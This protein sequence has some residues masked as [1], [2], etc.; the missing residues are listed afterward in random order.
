[1]K[2]ILYNYLICSTFRRKLLLLTGILWFGMATSL[3]AQKQFAYSGKVNDK[4]GLTLPGVTVAVKGTTIGTITDM[5]GEFTLRT[6]K[7]NAVLTFSLLGFAT[8]E[9]QA[10][11]GETVNLVLEDKSFG[12][13][14]VMIVGYGT[15]KKSLVTGAISQIKAQDIRSIPAS[16]VEQILTGRIAGVSV[17]SNSG[18][19]GSALKVRIRGTGTN[20]N[21][22]PLYI[23][24][25]MKSGDITYLEPSDVESI[26]VLKDAGS[27]AIYG[28]E[29]GNGVVLITTKSGKGVI[30]GPKGGK[31]TYDFQ[32]GWQSV[33]KLMKVMN[34][35]EYATYVNE[36]G[37]KV[38]G[39]PIPTE[40]TVDTKWLNEIATI[41]P[42]QKHYLSFSGSTDQSNYMISGSY[43][44]QDGVVGGSKANFKRYSVRFNGDHQ[45]KDWFQIG[46]NFAYSH[47]DRKAITENSEFGG[48]VSSALMMDPLTPVVYE[49]ALPQFAIDAQTGGATLLT[50]SKGQYY[51]LSKYLKGESA[52]PLAQI[53]LAKGGTSQ[54]KVLGSFFATLK[55]IKGLSITSRIGV[56]YAGQLY[57]TWNPT[58]WF[59]SERQNSIPTVGQNYDKWMTWLW[60]NFASYSKKIDKNNFTLLVGISAQS[61]KHNF[62]T[63][64][65]DPKMLVEGDPFAQYGG[66]AIDGKVSGNEEVRTQQSYFGR[67]SYDYDGKYLFNAILRRDGSSMFA[68][69]WGN[70][71]SLSAG[72]VASNENFWGIST[73]NYFKV[74]AS[75]GANG[76]LSNLKPDQFRSLI[77]SSGIR[78]PKP[79]G[80]FYTGAEP[81]L[82]ANPDLGWESSVQTD[83]G[84]DMRAFDGKISLSADYYNKVTKNLL[85]PSTPPISVGNS[86]PFVNA[87]DVTNK[88][89]E[90]ELGYKE[91]KGEFHYSAN[92]NLTTIK[93]NV[94]YLN[95][96]LK[97][98]NGAVVGTG[99][100]ATYFAQGQP[101]WYFSGYK[102]NGIFQNQAQIDKYVG[103]NGLVGYTPK[104]GDPIVVNTNGDKSIN[105]DDMTQIGN[106]QPKMTL[107]ANLSADFKGFDLNIFVQGTYGNDILL[108]WNRTD[109]GT[110]NRPEFFFTDRWTGEGSTNTWFRSDMTSPY[111]YN[112]D[113]MVYS[114]SYLRIKQI[115]LGYTLPKSIAEK[116]HISNLRIYVSMDDY[117][118]FTKYPGM[119]P[120]A[121][122]IGDNSQ[123]I[124][125]G[126]YPTPRKIMTGLSISL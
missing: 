26:E 101:V 97:R 63:T 32:Q 81:E 29:G 50:N 47:T 10:T 85:T 118:T 68:N 73:I 86:S 104:P 53:E 83:L 48:I 2:Q 78:Y 69:R 111:A 108:A 44:N 23:V 126:M 65:A 9:I 24:D 20:G 82:L 61:Y 125:R 15:Q 119:D 71:P 66:T 39:Q 25:G 62:A 46:N 92:V 116:M 55:P 49:G 122:A 17:R 75:W 8:Q 98:I 100:T 76:S 112:S 91:S 109:R 114:G 60:E 84:I 105:E 110:S 36:A 72:W 42:M 13:S 124:D 40:S 7:P 120:E 57:H 6:D 74:R 123:G 121:G 96:L 93:N 21:S 30:G 1:M 11:P 45:L 103:D 117:F 52:N 38:D 107:G 115:Q 12:L 59:S 80:G 95:P 106:P 16:R 94:T 14:E 33:G 27:S 43:F 113:L 102:T 64:F 4:Q 56:D 99:W 18:S 67:L 89:F 79:G 51:G 22:D 35:S 77:T 54:D 41:A 58:Y 37:I 19:P 34:A 88:G 90:F 31:I 28:S 5:N 70:F 3:F 87:G